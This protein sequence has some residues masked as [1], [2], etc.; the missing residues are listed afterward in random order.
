M[1]SLVHYALIAV[2]AAS[3][4]QTARA[5]TTAPTMKLGLSSSLTKPKFDLLSSVR[6]AAATDKDNSSTDSI[7][8]EFERKE[9][10]IQKRREEAMARLDKYETTLQDLQ[11][12]KAEYQAAGQIAAPPAGGTFS[13]TTMRSA[14]K[15]FAWRVVAGTITFMTTLQFSGSMKTALQVVGTDFFSK[16]AT[17]FM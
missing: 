10:K 12:K 15:A 5:F 6:G 8:K 9:A 17:M 1:R 16:A 3:A 11:S 2:A 7:M 14:V 13:E 4:V